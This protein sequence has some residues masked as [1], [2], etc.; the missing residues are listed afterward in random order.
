MKGLVRSSLV[1][2]AVGV[3]LSSASLFINI[4]TLKKANKIKKIAN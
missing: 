1:L 3:A 2:S 4:L